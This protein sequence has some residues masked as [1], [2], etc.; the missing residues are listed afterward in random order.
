LASTLAGTLGLLLVVIDLGKQTEQ[1]DVQP[2]AA[3]LERGDLCPSFPGLDEL[4]F[5][6][7]KACR[8]GQLLLVQIR[9]EPKLTEASAKPVPVFPF[10]FGFA[11]IHRFL[12]LL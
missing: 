6:T 1:G 2:L 12:S 9:L 10:V 8:L 7:G 11:M 3:T 4:Q 5:R